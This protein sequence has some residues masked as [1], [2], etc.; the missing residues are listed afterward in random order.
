MSLVRLIV[1]SASMEPEVHTLECTPRVLLAVAILAEKIG[2]S[3]DGSIDVEEVE[4]PVSLTRESEFCRM[5]A[6]WCESYSGEAELIIRR[7]REVGRS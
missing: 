6:R 7:L 5:V 2:D 3:G 1:T 4:G